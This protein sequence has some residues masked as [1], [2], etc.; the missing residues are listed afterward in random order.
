MVRIGEQSPYVYGTGANEVMEKVFRWRCTPSLQNRRAIPEPFRPTTLQTMSMNHPN[1]IDFINWGCIRD[2]LIYKH[3]T[4][5]MEQMFTDLLLNTVIEIPQF[6]VS[7][8]ILDTFIQ[9]VFSTTAAASFSGK[10]QDSHGM[11]PSFN[12]T[13]TPP[14]IR[15]DELP[16][17]CREHII[18]I[19]REMPTHTI[20]KLKLKSLPLTQNRLQRHQLASKWGLYQL[21]SWKVSKEFAM[22]HP[23]IDCSSG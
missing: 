13:A 12:T 2:Q 8:N 5:D 17:R 18:N 22:V 21:V 20:P 4:Y 15:L 16:R 23:E 3:G 14:T 10:D 7:I 6:Q 1:I 9:I 19:V 11:S